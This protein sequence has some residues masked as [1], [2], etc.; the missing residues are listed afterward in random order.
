MRRDAPCFA[1]AS[2]PFMGVALIACRVFTLPIMCLIVACG[3]PLALHPIHNP[4]NLRRAEPPYLTRLGQKERRTPIPPHSPIASRR[5]H[6]V[7]QRLHERW[8]QRQ[9]TSTALA[10]CLRVRQNQPPFLL[11]AMPF[12]REIANIQQRELDGAQSRRQRKRQQS[13]IAL[14]CACACSWVGRSLFP[15]DG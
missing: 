12:A 3:N 2:T 5:L 15:G 7:E 11:L 8:S 13:V 14:G 1:C 6:I 10:L 9:G 4:T